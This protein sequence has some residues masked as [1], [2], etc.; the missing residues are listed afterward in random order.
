[1]LSEIPIRSHQPSRHVRDDVHALLWGDRVK[2]HL[3]VFVV[4]V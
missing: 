1:M 3:G 4:L 2:T